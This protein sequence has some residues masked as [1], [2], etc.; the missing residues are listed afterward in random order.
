MPS[1][2]RGRTIGDFDVVTLAT[3]GVELARPPLQGTA[4]SPREEDCTV[5]VTFNTSKGAGPNSRSMT[6]PTRHLAGKA[7]S[8][9]R[10]GWHS[11]ESRSSARLGL[12]LC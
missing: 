10:N 1:L 8:S 6:G 9:T 3:G 7:L 4:L 11:K 2:G 12:T 5:D